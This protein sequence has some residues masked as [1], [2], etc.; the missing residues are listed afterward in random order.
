[1]GDGGKI[2]SIDHGL[3]FH[4]DMKVRTVIWDFCSDPIPAHLLKSLTTL[5]ERLESPANSLPSL[6][7]ELV[8]LL[9]QDEVDALRRRLDWIL[10][11]RVYPGLPGR[12][13][14]RG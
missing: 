1:M 9:P 3:T 10:E 4:S 6:L 13:R 14:R 2:W 5:R 11:E 12:N 8:A 7:K